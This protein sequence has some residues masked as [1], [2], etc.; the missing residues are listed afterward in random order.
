MRRNH[1]TFITL[2]E[3][4]KLTEIDYR[5]YQVVSIFEV[6]RVMGG[7]QQDLVSNHW[8]VVLLS[9]KL[10]FGLKEKGHS[11]S[12]IEKVAFC[13]ALRRLKTKLIEGTLQE[14]EP[15]EEMLSY[16]DLV[17]LINDCEPSKINPSST[18]SMNLENEIE[19]WRL[20]QKK[21]R[22]MGFQ[23]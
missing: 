17:R 1:D 7:F 10:V 16:D 4:L 6:K 12:D 13:E 2:A 8:V 20:Q 18:F 9:G 19:H 14:E 22:Q 11:E 23:Q 5:N 21:G 3:D 15:A